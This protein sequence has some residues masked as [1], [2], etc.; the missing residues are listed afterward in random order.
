MNRLIKRFLSFAAIIL[1]IYAVLYCFI[2]RHFFTLDCTTVEVHNIIGNYRLSSYCNR[3]SMAIYYNEKEEFGGIP[4]VEETVYQVEWNDRWIIARNHPNFSEILAKRLYK[5]SIITG[6]FELKTA[7]DTIFL[8]ENDSIYCLN[9]KWYHSLREWNNN[10]SLRKLLIETNYFFIDT[11]PRAE[12]ERIKKKLI[13]TTTENEF[14]RIRDSLR[15]PAK[16]KDEII[17]EDLK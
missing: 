10:D 8:K 7:E 3:N 16:L 11:K 13:K 12:Y 14:E 17:L 15:L 4:I 2:F 6:D 1:I 5:P 9:G